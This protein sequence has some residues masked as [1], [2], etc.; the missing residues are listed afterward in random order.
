MNIKRFYQSKLDQLLHPG[1]VLAL[2]G[3]RRAGKT[4]LLNNFLSSF[5]GKYFLGSGEDRSIRDVFSSEDVHLIRSSF[6]GYE[7]VVIDEAQAIPEVGN[8]LK[9]LVDHL[10]KLKVIASGSSSFE[11]A[12]TLGEPLTGR[13]KSLTLYPI[14]GIELV[15]EFGA[16][17]LRQRQEEL[18]IY[19]SYPEVLTTVNFKDKME[20]LHELRDSYL[21]KDILAFD[22]VRNADKLHQLLTLLVFQVGKEVS[23]SELGTQ[24]GLSKQTVERYLDLLEKTFVIFRISGFSR[25]LRSEV[26]KTKRYYFY[27]NG[28]MN[29]VINNFNLLHLRADTG[30]LWENYLASERLKKQTYYRIFANN[31]FWRTYEHQE[32]DWLEEREGNLF[33]YEFKCG[34][35]VPKAP[36]LWRENYPQSEFQVINQKNFADFI[37]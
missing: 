16:M 34:D 29:A 36:K 1:K 10:P 13:K 9:L 22:K 30:A 21:F 18:L 14:S 20:L 26:T 25:N 23:L 28:V 32:L 11:L 12:N 7:L 6:S 5:T 8:G 31:Y 19:G 15:A 4:T 2:Y 37:L 17:A 33:A 27:D 35:K 24:L 3:P